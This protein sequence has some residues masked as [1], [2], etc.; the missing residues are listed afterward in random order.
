M[1]YSLWLSAIFG[2][3]VTNIKN[4]FQGHHLKAL[5]ML[6]SMA[7]SPAS[8]LNHLLQHSPSHDAT[9]NYLSC[10]S[11]VNWKLSSGAKSGISPEQSPASNLANQ[12]NTQCSNRLM[13]QYAILVPFPGPM[14]MGPGNEANQECGCHSRGPELL[15][16]L[17]RGPPDVHTKIPAMR[18]NLRTRNKEIFQQL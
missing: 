11:G 10:S 13:V 14:C 2:K 7:Q 4:N 3:N 17:K 15:H 12:H 16:L 5:L 9:Y 6:T 18:I 1:D 8:Y